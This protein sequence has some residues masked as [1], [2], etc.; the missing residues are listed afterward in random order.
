MSGARSCVGVGW[1]GKCE[2]GSECYDGVV[3]GCV[4]M[5]VIV[6]IYICI[7]ILIIKI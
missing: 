4:V 2:G 5:W 6:Y 7:R 3:G 1:W